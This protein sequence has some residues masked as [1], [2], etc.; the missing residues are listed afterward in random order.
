M[1]QE[2]C[3]QMYQTFA[4]CNAK[5]RDSSD[6]P[7]APS[8]NTKISASSFATTR[9]NV[10]KWLQQRLALAREESEI[11]EEVQKQ[12]TASAEVDMQQ[13]AGAEVDMQKT[14]CAEVDMQQTASAEVDMQQKTGAEAASAEVDT[15]Q[16]ASAEIQAQQVSNPKEQL[17]LNLQ[18]ETSQSMDCSLKSSTSSHCRDSNQDSRVRNSGQFNLFS[19]EILE[20]LDKPERLLKSPAQFTQHSRRSSAFGDTPTNMSLAS[21]PRTLTCPQ[22]PDSRPHSV[23]S[24]QLSMTSPQGSVTSQYPN[25]SVNITKMWSHDGSSIEG[26]S[27]SD[28]AADTHKL[29]KQMA[30]HNTSYNDITSMSLE[31]HVN[32]RDSLCPDPTK[33]CVEAVF[34][35]VHHDT[36]LSQ[37]LLYVLISLASGSY[38]M[39]IFTWLGE[40]VTVVPCATEQK[41]LEELTG[42]VRRHDP[43]LLVGWE[44]HKLSW[45]YLLRRSMALKLNLANEL[46]RMPKVVSR[47]ELSQEFVLHSSEFARVGGR[48]LVNMWKVMRHQMG[49]GLIPALTNYNF[50]NVV[51]SILNL[52]VPKFS[53]RDLTDWYQLPKQRQRVLDYYLQRTQLLHQMEQQIDF[54]GQTSEFA[55]VYGIEF[56]DVIIKGTQYKVESMMLRIAK[57]LN[58][59][60]VSPNVQQRVKM[61]PPECIQLTLEPESQF[62][63]DPVIVLDFQSLYPSIMIAYNYC[64]ST[65]LGN[66]AE[67]EKSGGEDFKFGCTSLRIPAHVLSKLKNHINVSPQWSCICQGICAEG[68]NLQNGGG[69]TGHQTH[70]ET[71]HVPVQV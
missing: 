50:E 63:A 2:I 46:S 20:S 68:S 57:P 47:P 62:Y 19:T 44:V 26:V 52:R 65:C 17:E 69:D 21:D 61:N 71:L 23:T 42:I 39:P 51:H 36:A 32:T 5:D 18:P 12:Q 67:L 33:D 28:R 8:S 15:Q 11:Q 40:G 22:Q 55:R 7:L 25:H 60:A 58:F 10:E 3:R 16:A 48:I 1:Q 9:R 64:F 37:S 24:P 14:A 34:L 70:G 31:L 35:H 30:S 59:V 54:I 29:L 4:R 13:A 41:L 45:G 38:H 66:I 43:D 6:S 27:G 49:L 53:Y 56:C